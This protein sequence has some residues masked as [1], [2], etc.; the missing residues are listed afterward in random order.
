MFSASASVSVFFARRCFAPYRIFSIVALWLWLGAV[1]FGSDPLPVATLTLPSPNHNAFATTSRYDSTGILYAWDGFGV[2]RQDGI[3]LDSYTQIGT[4][5]GGNNEPL[6]WYGSTGGDY[7]CADAGPINF[8]SDGARI[9]LGNGL[10]GWGP[11]ND[12]AETTLSGL[13]C[14]MPISGGTVDLPGA[15]SPVATID[16]HTDFIPLPA[17]STVEN[18]ATKYFVNQGDGSY[19]HSSILVFDE[20]TG[21]AVP[22]IVN[23]PGATTSLAFNPTTNRL[24]AGVGFGSDRGKIF[25]FTLAQLDDAFLNGPMDFTDGELFNPDA[26][27]NQSGAGMFFD[28][29]GYLFAGGN[30]GITCFRPNGEVS[31]VLDMGIYTSLVYN[32]LNDQVL[33]VTGFTGETGTVY[34]ASDFETVPEPSAI[35]L[36]FVGACLVWFM[37]HKKSTRS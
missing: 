12:P 31:M 28:A 16:Y 7:N 37:Q 17:A 9:L 35:L 29:N 15:D 34:N 36:L 18:N 26:W 14:A 11:Y 23:G 3:N 30:E 8:S 4:V 1:A 32:P 20:T 24:Y 13:I 10:G 6:S 33:A 25:S 27:D 2:W 21:N 22:V 19:T 5:I